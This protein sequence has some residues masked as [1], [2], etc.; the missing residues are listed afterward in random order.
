M[1]TWEDVG[2]LWR[3]SVVRSEPAM[4]SLWEH[5]LCSGASGPSVCGGDLLAYGGPRAAGTAEFSS[6]VEVNERWL[7]R[8]LSEW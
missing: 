8:L 2:F 4:L 7:S 6:K 1:T 5:V 3:C